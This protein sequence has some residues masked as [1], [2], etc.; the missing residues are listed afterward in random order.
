MRPFAGAKHGYAGQ[1][2]RRL[3]LFYD[4]SED[5]FDEMR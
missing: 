4:L 5:K 2:E 3:T 1:S